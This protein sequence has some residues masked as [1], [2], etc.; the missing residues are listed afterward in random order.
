MSRTFS[1]IEA[2]DDGAGS[3]RMR[4]RSIGVWIGAR[5]WEKARSP[6]VESLGIGRGDVGENDDVA[7]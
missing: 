3:E 7:E 2:A 1:G 5:G 6:G 4:T